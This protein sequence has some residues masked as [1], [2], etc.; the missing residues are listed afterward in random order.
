MLLLARRGQ[1][2]ENGIAY[3]CLKCEIAAISHLLGQVWGE[4]S[5][6][7]LLDGTVNPGL[8]LQGDHLVAE[9]ALAL[10]HPQPQ[11][12]PFWAGD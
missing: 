4:I 6:A 7:Q 8:V 10:V 5:L 9:D 11:Q 12:V 3:R 2:H 1:G